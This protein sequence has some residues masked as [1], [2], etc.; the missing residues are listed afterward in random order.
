MLC[1]E[2]TK[3]DSSFR[4]HQ[5]KIEGYH[6]PPLRR[7]QD[8]KGG[9][10]MVLVREGFIAKQMKNFETENAEAIC[11]E[12]TIVKE[13]GAF[14]LLTVPQTLIKKNFLMKA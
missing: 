6:F 11:L 12:L 4:N 10:K 9:G 1:I 13:S 3:L 7:D 2:E 5:F 8:S 14:F